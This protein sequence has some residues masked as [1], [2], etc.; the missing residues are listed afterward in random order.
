MRKNI[1][2]R[3][4]GKGSAKKRNARNTSNNTSRVL[5]IPR[6]ALID[7]INFT[8]R[9]VDH[10]TLIHAS[11]Y[12]PGVEQ[13]LHPNYGFA[14]GSID[15]SWGLYSLV[16]KNA[17]SGFFTNLVVKKA[18]IKVVITNND[19]FVKQINV[20]Q[21]PYASS[22]TLGA[23]VARRLALYPNCKSFTLE[24][25]GVQGDT[26]TIILSFDLSKIEGYDSMKEYENTPSY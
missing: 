10:Y 21:I 2:S 6:N 9:S 14:N 16:Y 8:T 18:R 15:N 19:S 13:T 4:G 5:T 26:K 23:N 20:L 3:P 7:R 25:A 1:R 24:K 12:Y 11:L 17:N 22:A